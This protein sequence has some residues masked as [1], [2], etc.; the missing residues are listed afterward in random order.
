VRRLSRYCN[1][2]QSKRSRAASGNLSRATGM[3]GN[4][5]AGA[6]C[7]MSVKHSVAYGEN[8]LGTCYAP[9]SLQFSGLPNPGLDV[10]GKDTIFGFVI[11][12]AGEL[13]HR[14]KGWDLDCG[15]NSH[16]SCNQ[17]SDHCCQMDVAITDR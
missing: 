12:G 1:R 4:H 8:T 13:A 14:N 5:L 15:R 16:C 11:F 17:P 3:F 10:R 7:R 6:P 2:M 9:C